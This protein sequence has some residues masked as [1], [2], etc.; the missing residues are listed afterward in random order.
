MAQSRTRRIVGSKAVKTTA[1][2]AGGIVILKGFSAMSEGDSGP[3]EIAKAFPLS[4]AHGNHDVVLMLMDDRSLRA[5][6]PEGSVDATVINGVTGED[7]NPE[8]LKTIGEHGGNASYA[9]R[10]TDKDGKVHISPMTVVLTQIKDKDIDALQFS[11]EASSPVIKG[12]A[13]PAQRTPSASDRTIDP[14]SRG[15][16]D[17]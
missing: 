8:T 9:V 17:F 13:G 11:T 3:P 10:W 14:K 7:A 15:T 16:L 4:N 6:G 5:S 12:L 1:A 2:I